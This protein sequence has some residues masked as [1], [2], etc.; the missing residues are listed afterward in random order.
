MSYFAMRRVEVRHRRQLR[1]WRRVRFPSAQRV[2]PSKLTASYR[3]DLGWGLVMPDEQQETNGPGEPARGKDEGSRTLQNS[4][5]AKPANAPLKHEA[6]ASDG[7][8]SAP[9]VQ[10]L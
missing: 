7:D 10:V 3:A 5:A 4:A 2:G 6:P 1:C 9:A 8:G